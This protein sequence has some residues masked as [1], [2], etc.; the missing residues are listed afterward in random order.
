V[1]AG[2]GGAGG[3][4][5]GPPADPAARYGPLNNARQL[6]RVSGFLQ[7]LPSHARVLTGG[8]VAGDIGYF[9]QPTVVADVRQDDEITQREVFGPVLIVQRFGTE[10]DAVR[11]ANGV[12]YG[13]AAGVWTRDHAQAMRMCR[14]LDYGTVRVNT[15]FAYPS[16]MPH[17]GF[18]HSGFG[19]DLSAY[20]L[21]DY[22]RIK[23]VVHHIGSHH[24]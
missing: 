8:A 1:V 14:L 2:G 23:H 15:H 4:P 24:Q 16:E 22:S 21:D 20:A 12:D 11:L 18:K 5:P 9:F 6:E 17:G 19:K 3:G 7:R 13:L 10:G